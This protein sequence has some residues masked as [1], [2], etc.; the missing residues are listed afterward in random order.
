[1]REGPLPLLLLDAAA[2]SIGGPGRENQDAGWAGPALAAVADGVGG[3]VGG[4]VA[5]ALAVDALACALGGQSRDDA[6]GAIRSAVEAAN[7]LLGETA[8]RTPE[9]TGMATTLTAAALDRRGR[10]AL[11]HVGDSRAYVLRDGDLVRLTRDHTLVQ[12]LVDARVIS[13][14]EALSHPL[15]SI[16]VRTLHG[17][18]GDVALVERSRHQVRP[19]DRLLVCSDGLSGVVPSAVLRSVLAD[20]ASPA[21]AVRRALRAALDAGAQD[22]V[23]AVVADVAVAGATV[24]AAPARVG[25]GSAA[26]RRLMAVQREAGRAMRGC[27]GQPTRKVLHAHPAL[28]PRPGTDR[29]R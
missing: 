22:D 27:S 6:E 18:D 28:H 5:A 24:P 1:M 23:T 29:P 16:V 2:G 9:L 3:N 14:E 19:G 15:R 17:R 10:L 25:A 7:A 11:A 13:A 26:A 12:G 4:A 21:G 20:E 8:G